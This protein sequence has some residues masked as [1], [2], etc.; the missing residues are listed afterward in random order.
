MI[1]RCVLHAAKICFG[2]SIWFQTMEFGHHILVRR[3]SETGFRTGLGNGWVGFDWLSV[4]FSVSFAVAIVTFLAA[5]K[6]T[7]D[8]RRGLEA[9]IWLAA[10]AG[11]LFGISFFCIVFLSFS[12][13]H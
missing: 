1:S 6:G 11:I 10:A 5:A 12:I 3:Y 9:L 4:I 8:R 2:M 7:Q 13:Q